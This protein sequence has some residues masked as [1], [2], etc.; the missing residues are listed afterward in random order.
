MEAESL[1]FISYSFF[2]AVVN[3][4]FL[5]STL[6]GFL[7]IFVLLLCSALVSGAEIAFFSLSGSDLERIEQDPSPADR[8]ILYLKE[9]PRYLLA[10]ILVSNNFINIAIILLSALVLDPLLSDDLFGYWGAS[11]NSVL[12]FA[13]TE[14]WAD[15]F[16]FLI[17]TVGISFL[18]VLFGEVTPKVYAKM[19]NLRLARFM[20]SPLAFLMRI[21]RPINAF[22]VKMTNLVESRLAKSN[23][24]T[25]QPSREE[26]DEAI[27]LTVSKSADADQEIDI[28]KSIVKFGEVSVKQ[29][30]RPRV[31]RMI[32]VK[33]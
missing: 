27:E 4:P 19:N 33:N 24:S 6:A 23:S 17:V 15:F 2:V 12:S 10:T 5:L 11:V 7:G 26:I 8:R 18:L 22:L 31:D 9:H 16:K 14:Q 28:L 21:L 29:I 32:L 1:P 25:N 20:A 30:M 3:I 13:S